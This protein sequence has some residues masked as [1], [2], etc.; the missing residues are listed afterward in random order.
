[1][2]TLCISLYVDKEKIWILDVVKYKY[3]LF[4]KVI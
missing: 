1:M 4:S 3:V 2:L